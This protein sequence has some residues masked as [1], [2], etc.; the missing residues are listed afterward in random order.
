M[1][2]IKLD[3]YR[4][5]DLERER[6]KELVTYLND[7]RAS[8]RGNHTAILRSLIEACEQD[9]IT[10]HTFSIFIPWA[11][12]PD[13]LAVCLKH[14]SETSIRQ[15]AIKELGKQLRRPQRFDWESAWRALGETEGLVKIFGRTSVID[16]KYLAASIGRSGAGKR[17]DRRE[18]CV[19]D[20]LRALLPDVYTASKIRSKEM[21]PVQ[22]HYARMLGACSQS[23]VN[24]ILNARNDTNPLYRQRDMRRLL[25]SHRTLLRERAI[26]H[27]FSKGPEDQDVPQYLQEFLQG[28]RDFALMALQGRL[29]GTV[30]DQRWGRNAELDVL[31]PI[32]KR[33]SR[34]R[35]AP[36]EQKRQVH[37]L[38]KLGLD[39][40]W[41]D[42]SRTKAGSKDLWAMTF[43]RWQVKPDEYE[44][45]LRLGFKLGLAKLP[46]QDFGSYSAVLRRLDAAPRKR[47]L[48]LCYLDIPDKGL[49]LFSAEDYSAFV[50]EI[51]PL[52]LIRL[53][54]KD[55][56]IR[57]L[58]KLSQLNPEYSF[59]QTSNANSIIPDR[60]AGSSKNFNVDLCLTMLQ[61]DDQKVQEDARQAIDRFRKKAATS[62]EPADRAKF[63]KA[64]A[65]CAIATGNLDTY[66]ETVTWQQRFVRDPLAVKTL[67][68][69]NVV[70][71]EEGVELLTGIDEIERLSSISKGDTTLLPEVV[72]HGIDKADAMLRTFQESYLTAKLEPSFQEYDWTHVKA[73]F[74]TVFSARVLRAEI[75][76][77]RFA[78]PQSKVFLVVW[79]AWLASLEW[80][81]SQFLSNLTVP[82][83]GLLGRLTPTML[84]DCTRSLLT[85]GT[86]SR[87]RRE[88]EG[89]KKAGSTDDILEQLS[90]YALSR[91]ASS[92]R[93]ALASPLILQTILDR[94]DASS[95]HRIL[96]SIGFLKRLQAAEAHDLLLKLA[97]GIGEK[98]EEQSYVR[99]GE[100]EVPKHV[101]SQPAVKV[102]TVKYLAQLLNDADFLPNDA[103]VEILIELF[104][105]AQHRDIRLAA[106][107][108]LLSLLDSLCS[109]TQDQL[110]TNPA[111]LDI[112]DALG[113][114]VPV[115]GSI[116]ERK[117]LQDTDWTEAEATS[118]LPELSDLGSDDLPPLMA[119]LVSAINGTSH[120]GLKKLEDSYVQD[121]IIPVLERCQK[122]HT[123]WIDMFLAKHEATTLR[124]D[125][126]E[127]PLAPRLWT[128]ILRNHYLAIPKKHLE[129]FS[130]YAL[131]CI[132]P[133]AAVKAFNARLRTDLELRKNPEVQHWLKIYDRSPVGFFA[134]E[135]NTLLVVLHQV[136]NLPDERVILLD[137]I[138]QHAELYLEDYEKSPDTWDTFLTYLAPSASF[139]SDPGQFEEYSNTRRHLTEQFVKLVKKRR[140]SGQ[141]LVL[142]T[143]TK[144]EFWLLHTLTW[145]KDDDNCE[146]FTMR[147][148][149]TLRHMLQEDDT[150]ILRWRKIAREACEV[151]SAVLR[152]D[153]ERLRVANHL[154]KLE[155]REQT[156]GESRQDSLT[157][158]LVKLGV[159]L[160]LI[161]QCKDK[162]QANELMKD[163][164]EEWQ[165]HD[166][167][168]VRA[169]VFH[170]Q[171]KRS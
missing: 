14:E 34:Y 13:V 80:L 82:I 93:P 90:Y 91:L 140:Q 120:R 3:T 16:I 35:R 12:S 167:D 18:Q 112:M 160:K 136:R 98:L 151:I 158:D 15:A 48:Q 105:A 75:T 89:R 25:K 92:D 38:V 164:V 54:T 22:H 4:I 57:L 103:A 81:D 55:D 49:D 126:P 10:S 2:V 74:A 152:T 84:A 39:L 28:D 125:V 117:P 132:K 157:V 51:W 65:A 163:R 88:A 11:K 100:V 24:D 161:E 156:K 66:G 58:R 138:M 130:K 127:T 96:L 142:P 17:N 44:D 146:A 133:A 111:V 162:K 86:E 37:D 78:V 67:F 141:R 41:T 27:L 170:W 79:R 73:L 137:M 118:I 9:L 53:L 30:T 59:L 134:S 99:V 40:L 46:H 145:Y 63:A 68:S 171:K 1:A 42:K 95:W 168:A 147:L 115:A 64:A 116:N 21:R 19:E 129:A 62:R 110:K 43:S 155:R 23:F 56:Q 7:L 139:I 94:P 32:I 122:E 123:K 33:L 72:A 148:E 8:V 135:T 143:S 101:P 131:H 83:H 77:K 166:S 87:K 76:Q 165:N 121:L 144:T 70:H 45:V 124:D 149:N 169:R 20:L 150:T 61:R 6:V 107:D 50:N 113:T 60:K 153:E 69:R 71:T 47:L 128:V 52:D 26:N 106:L 29:D 119:A 154:G 85:L 108:S 159:A 104:R 36:V 31:I 97:L 102:T 5:Q 114:I 109:G